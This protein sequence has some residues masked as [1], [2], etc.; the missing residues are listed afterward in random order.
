VLGTDD[1]GTPLILSEAAD[2]ELWIIP[3][4]DSRFEV[5]SGPTDGPRPAAP[6]ADGSA[7]WFSSANTARS[8]T[9]FRYTAAGGLAVIANFTDHPVTVAGPCA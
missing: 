4:P 3:T 5:W 6:I 9:I 2:E 7:V 1:R 8:W